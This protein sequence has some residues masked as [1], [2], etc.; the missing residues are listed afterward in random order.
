[1]IDF[2]ALEELYESIREDSNFE[3]L[4]AGHN[5][6]VGGEGDNPQAMIIGEAPG[7]EELMS[8]RPFVGPSGRVLRSLM[9]IAGF[10]AEWVGKLTG[11]IV[12]PKCNHGVPPNCWLTNVVKYRP[13]RNRTP[14][15]KE[16]A[17]FRPYLRREWIHI[18]RPQL[19]VTVGGV[20]AQAVFGKSIPVLE[21]A[22]YPWFVKHAAT[23]KTVCVWPMVHPSY[24][25]RNKEYRSTMERH[26]T[27]LQSWRANFS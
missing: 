11:A 26:W 20:A 25:L 8:G 4:R 24:A 15:L 6:L 14:T 10:H 2:D 27:E 5:R 21:R 16:I 23:A 22:G 19:I 7:A 3:H 13:L 18:G 9:S 17:D 1:M 12:P